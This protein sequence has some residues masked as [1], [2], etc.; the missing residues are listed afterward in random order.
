[1]LY[2]VVHKPDIDF[3]D[4]MDCG[5]DKDRAKAIALY[6]RAIETGKEF[7]CVRGL[8]EGVYE[9]EDEMPESDFG[10]WLV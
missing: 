1:M 4:V 8:R 6:R 7:R 9:S 3:T 2:G 5:T 10:M